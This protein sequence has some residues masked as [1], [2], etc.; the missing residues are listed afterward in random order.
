[1]GLLGGLVWYPV[2]F[3]IRAA[4]VVAYAR[5]DNSS[6]LEPLPASD[7]L[8]QLRLAYAA[9]PACACLHF[10]RSCC[11]VA[12][13]GRPSC[14]T[15]RP[16]ASHQS[17]KWDERTH[18]T[19]DADLMI[20]LEALDFRFPLL[21]VNLT[22][23]ALRSSRRSPFAFQCFRGLLLGS[24]DWNGVELAVMD[25]PSVAWKDCCGDVHVHVLYR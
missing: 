25:W 17:K 1:M 12:S 11:I 8:L 14:F 21:C 22:G 19:S 20:C 18:K 9:N 5:L 3:Q 24:T 6:Q 23:A 2:S 7:T 15:P 16:P 4:G 13:Q 10:D